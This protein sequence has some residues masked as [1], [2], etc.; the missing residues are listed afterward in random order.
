MCC[1]I[2][3]ASGERAAAHFAA[4]YRLPSPLGNGPVRRAAVAERD[5]FNRSREASVIQVTA[6]Q[7]EAARRRCLGHYF[8]PT[9]T[10]TNDTLTATGHRE[11]NKEHNI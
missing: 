9:T 5:D 6:L 10:S 8:Y 1:I 4:A 7:G 3:T 2:W 11:E